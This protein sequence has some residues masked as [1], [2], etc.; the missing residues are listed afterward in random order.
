MTALRNIPITVSRRDGSQDTIQFPESEFAVEIGDTLKKPVVTE[1]VSY[2]KRGNNDSLT[3]QCGRTER[4]NLGSKNWQ[5]TVEGLMVE[6]FG[7]ETLSPNDV[8]FLSDIGEAFVVS[9]YFTG[10]IVVDGVT[11]DRDSELSHFEYEGNQY[12]LYSFQLQLGEREGDS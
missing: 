2:D 4:R 8:V 11:F 7:D 10:E 9:N 1:N 6:D 12:E 5:I 3:D